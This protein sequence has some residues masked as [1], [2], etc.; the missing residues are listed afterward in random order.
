MKIEVGGVEYPV[1]VEHYRIEDMRLWDGWSEKDWR[2]EI[3][4]MTSEKSIINSVSHRVVYAFP[5]GGMTVVSVCVNEITLEA[6]SIC[7]IKDNFNRKVG[8]T[9]AIDRL[10]DKIKSQIWIN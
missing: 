8:R 2:E 7:S 3:D 1:R 4:R 9:I 5:R 6:C 10:K